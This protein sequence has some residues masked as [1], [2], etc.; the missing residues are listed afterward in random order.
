MIPEFRSDDGTGK[1]EA[2]RIAVDTEHT[3]RTYVLALC[4]A[5]AVGARAA[6]GQ[7][8]AGLPELVGQ[9]RVRAALPALLRAADRSRQHPCSGCKQVEQR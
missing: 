2:V 7:D 5:P 8:A 1:R 4:A 9:P 6:G 3:K